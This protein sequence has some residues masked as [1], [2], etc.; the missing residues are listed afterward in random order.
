[1][2]PARFTYHAPNSLAEACEMLAEH[3]EE[4]EVIAGGQSLVPVM[5]FRLAQPAKLIDINN[6][7]ELAQI[8]IEGDRLDVGALARHAEIQR[9]RT[10]RPPVDPRARHHRR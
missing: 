10:Y 5:N 4:G 8:R 2:K 3:G 1:M 9:S 7:G 6:I